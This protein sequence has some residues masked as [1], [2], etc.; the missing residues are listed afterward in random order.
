MKQLFTKTYFLIFLV[1]IILFGP[2]IFAGKALVWGTVS[3]QFIPWWDFAWESLL[4]GQI[5]LWNP[6]VGMGAP[7]VANY[8]S[9]IFYPPYWI[10]LL[11]YTL[12]GI[13]WM[14][15]GVTF[16]VVFHLIWSGLGVAKLLDELKLSK[17]AQ[18][19]GGLVFSMSGYLIARSS[20]L[21]INATVAWLPW[22]LLYCLRLANKKERAFW[23]LSAVLAIQLLAGH[24][25][26]AWYSIL[27]GA[28]WII[29]LA[30][31]KYREKDKPG[32]CYK[33]IYKYIL[34]GILGA[35][36][37]AIQLV[38][39]IEYLMQSQRSGEYGY[40]AAMTYSFWPWRFLAFL[41]PNLFGNPAFGNYWGYGNFWEDAIYIGLLPFLIAIGTVVRSFLV[42]R[43]NGN[44]TDSARYRDFVIF[45]SGIIFVSFLLALGD[46]TRLF[47]FLYQN[48]PTFGFF[49]APT[50]YSIWAEISLAI[51][52][53]IGID[54]LAQVH[55]KRKYWI[56]LSA[57]GCLAV[58]GGSVLGWLFL[59]DVNTTFFVP[60][61][62]AGVFGFGTAMLILFQPEKDHNQRYAFWSGLVLVLISLD[63]IIAGW[64]IHPGVEIEFYDVPRIEANRTRTYL[65]SDWEYDIKFGKYFRFESFTPEVPWEDMHGDL[66][67]NLPVLQ[68]V[69]LVNNFDPLVPS[70]FQ[71]WI[72]E[73]EILD[74]PY[75]HSMTRLMN[76]GQ[77]ISGA[78]GKRNKVDIETDDSY[79]EIRINDLVEIVSTEKK[80]LDIIVAEKYDFS[81][82]LVI[83]TP[84][85]IIE[86]DCQN[87]S[88]GDIRVEE[89]APGYIKVISDLDKSGWM[90]WSQSWYPGWIALIDGEEK[91]E[92]MRANYLFQAICVP[93]GIHDVEIIYQPKSFYLGVGITLLSLAVSISAGLILKG[94][95]TSRIA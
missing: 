64:N 41:V 77:I 8:Q 74:N 61:G 88:S 78:E 60:I 5:P 47:P 51:I 39:T 66:L 55:G 68:R 86:D 56:R 30:L 17:L 54:Q 10:L 42:K 23:A 53:G 7:L 3:T 87:G 31:R 40:A 45:L 50:R 70:R 16:V 28:A 9:A 22:L 38:P 32:F 80:A 90:I 6:W 73:Y 62:L 49:Q 27:L 65:A 19:A 59:T 79:A 93:A 25:Q 69:E 84:T 14:S 35:G 18:I 1:P 83:D 15:W 20:F 2:I 71:S 36:L 46:N 48:I 4:N 24:A 72:S 91:V 81:R 12:A 76:I 43:K 26:T 52:A 75:Q 57:A 63:L 33:I 21:S 92:V 67:P 11:I 29:F 58:V 85:G 37:S 95:E 82:N 34:A 94:K 13:K 89:T 44:Q